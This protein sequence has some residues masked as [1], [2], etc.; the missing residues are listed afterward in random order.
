M[1]SSVASFPGRPVWPG[2]QQL[3][4]MPR[5]G[6]TSAAETSK[7]MVGQACALAASAKHL[8]R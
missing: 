6:Q 5:G 4:S 1:E 2:R 8:G 7:Q 3:T